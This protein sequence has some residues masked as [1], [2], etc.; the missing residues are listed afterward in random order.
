MDRPPVFFWQNM[1]AHHQVGALDAFAAEWGAPVTGVWVEDMDA[2]RLRDGWRSPARSHLRDH[3]LP[4][5]GWRPNVDTLAAANLDAIHLFSGLGSYPP[6]TRAARIILKQAHPKAGLIVETAMKSPWLRIPNALKALGYYYP[7][8]RQIGAV[9]AISSLAENFYHSI[10]F[11]KTQIFPYLYQCDAPAPAVA[12]SPSGALRIIFVGR[13]APYKGLDILLGALAPLAGR[14]WTLDVYGDGP[15]QANVRASAERLGLAAQVRFRGVIPSDQVVPA[16]AAADL[17]VV[18]SRYDGW[19]MATS[20]ALRAGIPVLVSDAAGSRDLIA[21]SR[22]GEV[23]ASGQLA[24]L[25]AQLARRMDSPALIADEKL[26]A[27]AFASRISPAA[28]GAHLVDVFRHAFL[29][30]GVRPT[31]PWFDTPSP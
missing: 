9:M 24:Q 11:A 15:S 17:C 20:E 25:S 21:A 5:V 4:A 16:L 14:A 28:V 6:V 26:R 10:G 2:D 13:L 12:A 22:A 30:E 29:G 31:A 1:P 23:F 27:K 19:G 18:P 8:R 3:F 7:V